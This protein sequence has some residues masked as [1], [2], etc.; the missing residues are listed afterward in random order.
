MNEEIVSSTDKREEYKVLSVWPPQKCY[1]CDRLTTVV[2]IDPAFLPNFQAKC[3][4]HGLA[5]CPYLDETVEERD[6][7][8]E[9]VRRFVLWM[10]ADTGRVPLVARMA[11]KEIPGY[12][13]P[14]VEEDEE[15]ENEEI[16]W[17]A[18]YEGPDGV[19]ID[20]YVASDY[21]QFFLYEQGALIEQRQIE[22]VA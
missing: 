5:R 21:D 1:H 19:R 13:N 17:A 9:S 12:E 22:Q 15:E 20:S 4:L 11:V 3:A 14:N 7:E 6:A 10:H 2:H 18:R 16:G 8:L